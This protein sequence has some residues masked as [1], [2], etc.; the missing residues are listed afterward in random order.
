MIPDFQIRH[1][2]GH[3]V[4][5]AVALAM[6]LGVISVVFLTYSLWDRI[7]QLDT[8][9]ADRSEW[10][11]SQVEVEFLKFERARAAAHDGQAD[12]L[13]EVRKRFDILFSRM[14]VIAQLQSNQEV[15]SDASA[16]L[17]VSAILAALNKNIA[18]I[19]ADDA[20]LFA[21]MDGLS[22]DMDGVD[23]FPRQIALNAIP[24]IVGIAERE[25]RQ[26]VRLVEVL[27]VVVFLVTLALIVAAV[28][29]LRQAQALNRSTRRVRETSQRLATTLQGSL[30][31]VV[32]IDAKAR[33]LDFNGSA[34]TIFGIRKEDA[35]GK[36]AIKLLMAEQFHEQ[37]HI[38]LDLVVHN[39][40]PEILEGARREFELLH[41]DGRLFPADMSISMTQTKSGPIF[42]FYVRDITEKKQKEEEITQARDQAL[43]ASEEKSRFFAMIS[44]EM[45][46]PLNGVHSALQL[47]EGTPLNAEQRHFLKAAMTSD[48]ILLNQINDVL[49]IERSEAQ[50]REQ[51]IL[52]CD[53]AALTATLIATMAPLAKISETGLRI[54]QTGLDDR[55]VLTDPRAIQQILV[56]LL[57]NAVK[58][59]P[60]GQVILSA[61]FVEPETD[62]GTTCLQLDVRDN[63]PGIP[64][65]DIERIFDDFVSLDS[66]YERRTGGT[67]LGLGIVRRLVTQMSGRIWCESVIG[68]GTR[69]IV[70]LPMQSKDSVKPKETDDLNEENDQS[71]MSLLVVDDNQINRDLLQAMLHQMGHKVVQVPGG[72]EAIAVSRTQRFDAILM[73]ISMPEING[74]Q[75]TQAIHL[76]PGLNQKTPV[77]AVT[78]HVQTSERA[79]F[80]DAGLVGFLQKPLGAS[81]LKACLQAIW[82]GPLATLQNPVLDDLTQSET[83]LDCIQID[84]LLD[85]LGAD[86]LGRRVDL[87]RRQLDRDVPRLLASSDLK[88]TSVIAHDLAGITGMHGARQFHHLMREIEAAC[89]A[90]QPD[91]VAAEL[92]LVSSVWD[93]TCAAWSKALQP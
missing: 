80:Q 47:L 31:A 16:V 84:D 42:V 65:E 83:V 81:D 23:S 22:R 36:D 4:R 17:A 28:R 90:E 20:T 39:S 6:L 92:A 45:R 7:R 46:T 41:Q 12:A 93:N 35:L 78:A 67:G 89:L 3:W 48:E 44:H 1:S 60:R 27:V 19:D 68:Q 86:G 8:S 54:D 25:R 59:A 74:I 64:Q 62:Q 43:K 76:G 26:I 72:K 55:E 37:M 15:E 61:T 71:A 49:A 57:S 91:R 66:R 82:D 87:V 9:S 30:D 11:Y 10:A 73:D 50:P 14:Q 79:K 13:A 52:P 29:I 24:V 21:G 69:F 18:L 56:N 33:I 51:V 70:R 77:I 75:A 2:L 40:D 63:G 38:S 85:L 32:V 53:I 34:E 58:F 5:G 88:K